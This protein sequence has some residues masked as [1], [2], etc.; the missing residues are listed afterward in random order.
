VT[1]TTGTTKPRGRQLIDLMAST[2]TSE[3]VPAELDTKRKR[4]GEHKDIGRG[5]D[6]AEHQQKEG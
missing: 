5:P 3:E 6:R 2:K 4:D 1:Q